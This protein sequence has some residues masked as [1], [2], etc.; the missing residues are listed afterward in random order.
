MRS[1]KKLLS[2]LL[3]LCMVFSL[4]CT[5]FAAEGTADTSMAGKT[6]ILHSNDVHGAV[7][8]YAKI[9]ALKAEYEAKGADVILADAGDYSQGT[10]Y[11]STT[12]G[13]NAVALM[14][15][16]G[17][18]V[19]TIGNHEFDYGYENLDTIME[20]A[21]FQV[22]CADV[23][24][25][26]EAIFDANTIIEK[27][28]VK[29]GFFGLETPEAQTK[30]NPALI[31]DLEFVAGKDLYAC[32]QAQVNALKE[33]GADIII[34]LAHLGVDKESAP[35]RSVDMY[36][37]VTGIDFV[38]DGHSHSVMA[39]GVEK[40][41]T[42]EKDGAPVYAENPFASKP[43]QSTGTAFA[44]VGVIVIDDATKKIESNELVPM[45]NYEGSD[46]TVADAAKAIVDEIDAEYGAV[47]AKSD[48]DLNGNRDPGNRTEETNLG[49]LITDAMVWSVLKDEGSI[50]VPAANVV[51]I[52]NGGGIRAAI[53][54]GDITKKDVN[55][56]LPFGNTVA[57]VYVTGAELLEALEA[58]TYCTPTAVGGFPQVSGL[59]FTLNIGMLY[60]AN[61]ET[62]PA[63]TYY[64]P[65][66]IQRVTIDSINGQ[67]FD[68][69]ATY[70]V[71]TNN[72]CAAGGDTY[73]AFASATEQFDT[74]IPLDEALM[75]YITEE[76]NGVVG[77]AYEAPE[78]RITVVGKDM[79]EARGEFE[80]ILS[81][82]L[83]EE[84]YTVLSA[85]PVNKA[86]ALAEDAKNAGEME[87][88]VAAL[89]EAV[90]N[91]VFASN[92]FTDVPTGKWFTRAVDF[93]Q[94]TGLM[95]GMTPTT[96]G[97]NVTMTR[98]MVAAVLYRDAGAPS[99]EGLSCPFT[100]LKA[101]EYYVDA[102]IWAY[103]N[104]VFAGKTETTFA[105]NDTITREQMAAVL[106]RLSGEDISDTEND[107]AQAKILDAL[108]EIY[109]DADAVSEYA[110]IAVLSWNIAGVMV[111]D[112]DGTFRP[113]SG[114]TRAEFAT[115]M[116]CLYDLGIE[117]VLGTADDVATTAAAF[118]A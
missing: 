41:Q 39:A 50:K 3:A 64:G 11:V 18:D 86:I 85:E 49:N 89:K 52:T 44:N 17:Y 99:V 94:A 117:M 116:V 9:A 96:F 38:I 79:Y 104:G 51:A 59:K 8:G 95:A 19:A 7:A 107:E 112:T 56:V 101:D 91:L 63:S 118:A 113:A 26:G 83:P 77:E 1:S 53:A 88:A 58:S 29:I 35:N 31:K 4:T 81:V 5:A 55:T 109:K 40:I 114:L 28:G 27:G 45:E 20:D 15:A 2:L 54:K 33:Q 62:Y 110:R 16:A 82:L 22:L 92:T 25:D 32:A 14:N 84:C 80:D 37:N 90:P 61:D 102:V 46:K 111:G 10:V 106:L 100:D 69:K 24:K 103:N 72:F 34:C 21:E 65:K 48:V 36:D 108:R 105:P 68:A 57:V 70:A 60:D 115:I 76:L 78:G 97:P 75:A 87:T 98:A 74:G 42:G 13:A 43:I 93:V 47:F 66:T 12:K 6:V 67:P 73:Y 23:T 71:I 30:A